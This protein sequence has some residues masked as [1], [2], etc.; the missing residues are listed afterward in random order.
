MTQK[1]T[2]LARLVKA[3]FRTMTDAAIACG[4]NVSQFSLYV[5]GARCNR[6]TAEKIAQGF[7]V[8]VGDIWPEY[9]EPAG[10]AK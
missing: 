8:A 1:E 6:R 3:E 5:R 7:G 10:G 4:V 2:K 9:R